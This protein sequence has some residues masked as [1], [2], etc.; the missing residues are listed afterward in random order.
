MCSFCDADASFGPHDGA[1]ACDPCARRIARLATQS[2]HRALRAIW[3]F[4][5]ARTVAEKKPERMDAEA[6]DPDE[7]FAA[8]KRGVDKQLSA[9][10]VDSHL[11]LAIAYREMALYE[12]AVREAAVA[13]Q[14]TRETRKVDE[15]LGMLLT[16]PL[17]RPGGVGALR[18]RFRMN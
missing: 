5:G 2:D 1:R 15:A 14:G 4:A 8:F 11:H 17:L 9:D 7:V 10:D 3:S 13:L 12:D 18:V 16:A 6:P